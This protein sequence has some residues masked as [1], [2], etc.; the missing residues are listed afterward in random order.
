MACFCN[1]RTGTF[2]LSF[3]TESRDKAGLKDL[4]DLIKSI[5]G[6]PLI[7]SNWSPE[8]FH[9]E[10]AYVTAKLLSYTSFPFGLTVTGNL[11]NT[12]EYILKV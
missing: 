3:L 2:Y 5:G 10:D 1:Y 4:K 8:N 12:S 6:W 11:K 7:D 9:W